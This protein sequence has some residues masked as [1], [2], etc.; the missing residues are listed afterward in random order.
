VVEHGNQKEQEIPTIPESHF[1]V[2]GM[3]NSSKSACIER[4]DTMGVR[5]WVVNIYIE[6]FSLE[7][8]LRIRWSE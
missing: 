3:E 6:L 7:I 1:P 4:E 5:W 2:H 8:L